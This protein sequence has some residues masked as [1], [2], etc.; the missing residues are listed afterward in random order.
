MMGY[1]ALQADR[2]E[3]AVSYLELARDFPDQKLT[4]E[5]LL[6]RARASAATAK[7]ANPEE[8]AKPV[9]Q[10]RLDTRR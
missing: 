8:P 5:Q 10:V 2:P 9:E 6:T 3:E 7:D 1:C 4:A